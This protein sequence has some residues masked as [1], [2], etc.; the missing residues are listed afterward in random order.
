[1]Q[2]T[3]ALDDLLCRRYPALYADRHADMQSTAMCWGFEAGDG[4]FGIIDALSEVLTSQAS[5]AGLPCPAAQQVKQEAGSLRFRVTVPAP[6]RL[7][8]ALAEEM[9]RR[10]CEISGRPGRLRLYWRRRMA[11][12]AAGLELGDLPG[13]DRATTAVTEAD[14]LTGGMDIPPLAFTLD[15][16][17]RWRADV[18]T[19]PVEVP[20]GWRD[21]ADA[22]LHVVQRERVEFGPVSIRHIR[23]DGAGMRLDWDEGGPLLEGLPTMAAA[24]SKRLDPLSGAM[25]AGVVP[26]MPTAPKI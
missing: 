8:I 17:A 6:G 1:M 21:L 14:P 22:V 2:M 16:M 9:S 5:A 7:T 25:D 26:A 15:D 19:G 13:S 11:T 24:L 23:R 3:Q 4:W 10:V 18:L 20:A 12:L